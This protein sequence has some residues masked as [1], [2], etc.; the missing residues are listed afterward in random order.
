MD[1]ILFVFARAQDEPESLEMNIPGKSYS[2]HKTTV[3]PS[4]EHLTELNQ[5]KGEPPPGVF[6]AQDKPLS[7]EMKREPLSDSPSSTAMSREP[8]ADEATPLI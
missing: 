6:V 5:R 2:L 3:A 8:S 7:P 1:Q 4:A